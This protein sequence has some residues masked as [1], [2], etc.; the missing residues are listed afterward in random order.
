MA[1]TTAQRQDHRSTRRTPRVAVLV[2][3][4]LPWLVLLSGLAGAL[5]L[6]LSGHGRPAAP[7]SPPAFLSRA[8]G[9]PLPREHGQL[10]RRVPGGITARVQPD[11]Y[12][13]SGRGSSLSLAAAV[14]KAAGW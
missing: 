11:G 14:P 6:L 13:V 2:R 4:P 12:T 10:V 3:S 5:F 7:G 9:K 8:L 1:R